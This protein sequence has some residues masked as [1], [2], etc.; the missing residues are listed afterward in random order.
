[1][2]SPR[3]RNSTAR[4][5]GAWY[6]RCLSRRIEAIY[7]NGVFRPVEPVTG[8]REQQRVAP[9]VETPPAGDDGNRY[10]FRDL[11]WLIP[12]TEAEADEW[13]RNIDEAYG[14]VEQD[15]PLTW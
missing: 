15:D 3:A 13:Q 9:D 8:F 11:S 6:N 5:P 1:M 7:E 14:K 12:I 2:R 10:P 4:R